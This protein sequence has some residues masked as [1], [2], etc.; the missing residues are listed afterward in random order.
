MADALTAFFIGLAT[1]IPLAVKAYIEIAK[2]K[3]SAKVMWDGFNKRGYI[4]A[5]STGSLVWNEVECKWIVP[6][7][8]REIYKPI[9]EL[10]YTIHRNLRKNLGRLPGEMEI[11]W[12]I[13]S[14]PYALGMTMQDWMVTTACPQLRTH[15]YACIAI[16]STIAREEVNQPQK[17]N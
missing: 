14:Y 6:P 13:E 4:E 16:A 12:A 3:N 15:N 9:E 11:G 5:Q 10:L 7:Q 2:L 8:V 1:V 17:G